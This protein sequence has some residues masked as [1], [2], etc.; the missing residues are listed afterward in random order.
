MSLFAVLNS[1][2]S[3]SPIVQ[4]CHINIWSLGGFFGA[5]QTVFDLGLCLKA[6]ESGPVSEFDLAIPF[7]TSED[8]LEDLSD[9]LKDHVTLSLVFS[10]AADFSS[11]PSPTITYGDESLL[12][13]SI[14]PDRSC[15]EEKQCNDQVSVW[16]I[17]LRSPI[18]ADAPVYVRL[19]FLVT[20]LGRTWLWRK[21]MWA[22]NG[23]IVDFRVGDVRGTTGFNSRLDESR[24]VR[25]ERLYVFVIAPAWL[26]LRT[27]SPDLHYIRILEGRPWWD[28]LG[29]ATSLFGEEKLVIYQWRDTEKGVDAGRS[30]HSFLDLNRHGPY[31]TVWTLVRSTLVIAGLFG[32]VWLFLTQVEG[33][34]VSV[35]NTLQAVQS[36][37][38]EQWTGLGIAGALWL[39]W[40]LFKERHTLRAVR[41]QARGLLYKSI[42]KALR[43]SQ[44]LRSK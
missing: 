30:F 19:R 5:R 28:Y 32:L 4:D 29:S 11:E 2:Q 39:V 16:K 13:R 3:P 41:A 21:S 7:G 23:A 24:I 31:P 38:V 26:E 42:R 35:A 1:R 36:L 9:K 40:R 34:R 27:A 8:S 44:A 17:R 14:D 25:I 6:R 33:L 37:A 20:G 22:K 43:L 12:L 15:R 18:E 10:G